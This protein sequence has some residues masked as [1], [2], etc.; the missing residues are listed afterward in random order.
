MKMAK[1]NLSDLLQTG[2]LTM[3]MAV[4]NTKFEE[5]IKLI[6]DRGLEGMGPAMQILL[7]EAMVIERSLISSNREGDEIRCNGPLV[8]WLRLQACL[9]RELP[10]SLKFC[11]KNFE[12]YGLRVGA[13]L[14]FALGVTAIYCLKISHLR[15]IFLGYG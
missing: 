7:N 3:A 11:L 5:A 13:N 4:E 1:V 8:L 15:P 2:G 12:L 10:I 14:V 9:S 6:F